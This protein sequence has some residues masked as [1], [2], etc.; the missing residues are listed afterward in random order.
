MEITMAKKKHTFIDLFVEWENDDARIIIENK[1][2]PA[3]RTPAEQA[4]FRVAQ[5]ESV[6][7]VKRKKYMPKEIYI[8][9]FARG[10]R[11][12]CEFDKRNLE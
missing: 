10:V 8:H 4:A 2:L 6:W 3:R 9:W 12:W 11:W 7:K 5:G 1:N